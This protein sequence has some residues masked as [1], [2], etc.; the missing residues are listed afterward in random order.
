MG[1][2]LVV[3]E[4]LPARGPADDQLDAVEVGGRVLP[5]VA[6]HGLLDDGPDLG[7]VPAPD[8]DVAALDEQQVVLGQGEGLGLGSR[9]GLRVVGPGAD[10][11]EERE[12]G[13]DEGRHAGR[14][15]P[16][17]DRAAHEMSPG[18]GS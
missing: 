6:E 4:H 3:A 15:L 8:L 17:D 13:R 10:V 18:V 1:R 2:V 9:P 12:H 11:R 5:L 7:P 14:A 16:G